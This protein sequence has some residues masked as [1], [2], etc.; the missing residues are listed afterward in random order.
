[1][2]K[3]GRFRL[4]WGSDT[5]RGGR[6]SIE[7]EVTSQAPYIQL[8]SFILGSMRIERDFQY[9]KRHLRPFSAGSFVVAE[10]SLLVA[11]VGRFRPRATGGAGAASRKSLAELRSRL[12]PM[13]GNRR[14]IPPL[15]VRVMRRSLDGRN[16]LDS[17]SAGRYGEVTARISGKYR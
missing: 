17:R 8:G 15:H 10:E 11:R 1:M 5:R 4:D 13:I 7:Y 6:R 16:H 9:S 14:M 2:P 3:A 12:K